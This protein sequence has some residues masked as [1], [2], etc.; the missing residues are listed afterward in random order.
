LEQIGKIVRPSIDPII[1][2]SRIIG[3]NKMHVTTI[4]SQIAEIVKNCGYYHPGSVQRALQR[5]RLYKMSHKWGR[6]FLPG[7]AL[8]ALIAWTIAV[9]TNS[10]SM[11]L[12]LGIALGMVITLYLVVRFLL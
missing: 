10:I 11:A 1:E 9:F 8:I 12:L 7:I 5:A 2:K 6:Y 4:Q 3:E